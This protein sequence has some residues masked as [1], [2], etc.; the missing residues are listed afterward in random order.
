MLV[1]GTGGREYRNRDPPTSPPDAKKDQWTLGEKNKK[2]AS[3]LRVGTAKD[4]IQ[5]GKELQ[6]RYEK[7]RKL[8]K[9][10]RDVAKECVA[11]R[12]WKKRAK[13]G[14]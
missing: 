14:Q 11:D 12:K 10:E 5:P 3:S 4:C 1:S 8:L 7:A 13:Q 2:N 6:C 9:C